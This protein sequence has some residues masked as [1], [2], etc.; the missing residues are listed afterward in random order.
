[1]TGTDNGTPRHAATGRQAPR[2]ETPDT[3]QP[4]RRSI[5]VT[6]T[7]YAPTSISLDGS[8]FIADACPMYFET[9]EEDTSIMLGDTNTTLHLLFSDQALINL[10]RL[11]NRAVCAMLRTRGIPVPE[12]VGQ[13]SI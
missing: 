8:A 1:M 13:E 4:E 9:T 6:G 10:T 12:W 5:D 2:P 7:L 11:A 3:A